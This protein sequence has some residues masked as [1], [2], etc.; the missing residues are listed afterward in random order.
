MPGGWVSHAHIKRP[1]LP[2]VMLSASYTSPD[3]QTRCAAVAAE[4]S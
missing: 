1:S 3:V 4:L 2:S